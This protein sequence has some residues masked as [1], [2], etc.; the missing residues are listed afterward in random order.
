MINEMRLDKKN[1]V[2][3]LLAERRK[4]KAHSEILAEVQAVLEENQ[5]ER[6][7]IVHTITE[8]S[9]TKPNEFV[10]D[11]L[12][13]DK[14]FHLE[15]IRSICVDYRFRFLDSTLF[16][17]DIP[18][19]AVSIIRDLE[20]KHQTTIDGFKIAAPSK[21]F[22]LKNYDDPLLFAPIGNGYYYL[23]HKWGNDVNPFRKLLVRPFRN[24]ESF[25]LLLV[26]IS[27]LLTA[28]LPVNILGKT[29][30]NVLRIVSFLF[31]LKSMVGISIYY[32]FWQGKN[33]NED[34]WRS[35]YYN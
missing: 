1:L 6:D 12:E 31:V 25:I 30:E 27:F 35:K 5:R 23:I 3:E 15:Q 14:I 13:S 18:E 22:K 33:F 21:L 2:N 4:F 8:K 29:N 7:K 17:G 24:L 28:I 26:V 32:C 10:F 9:S 19:E 34:I 11:L 20:K 16:K